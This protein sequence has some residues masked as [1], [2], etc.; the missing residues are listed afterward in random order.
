MQSLKSFASQIP[1]ADVIVKSVLHLRQIRDIITD[2]KNENDMANEKDKTLKF[3]LAESYF[4]TTQTGER[5]TFRCVGRTN[6]KITLKDKH[7]DKVVKVGIYANE[8]GIE[9]CYP[10]G[11]Y[12]SKPVLMASNKVND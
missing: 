11:K 12:V 8:Q 5:L 9:F 3:E 2:I 4:C 6:K 7:Y 1:I 10:L